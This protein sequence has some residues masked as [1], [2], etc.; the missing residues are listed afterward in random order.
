MPRNRY[1]NTYKERKQTVSV[2]DK[3]CTSF[4]ENLWK[5]MTKKWETC[6]NKDNKKYIF[7]SSLKFQLVSEAK[8]SESLF[9]EKI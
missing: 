1:Y 7:K 2:N 6:I 4:S 9:L 3:L 8:V 5:F